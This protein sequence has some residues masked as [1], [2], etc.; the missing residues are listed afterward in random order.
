MTNSKTSLKRVANV[1]LANKVIWSLEDIIALAI[2]ADALL[3]RASERTDRRHA[4][5]VLLLQLEQIRRTVTEIRA[6]AV[7]AQHGDYVGNRLILPDAESDS[8]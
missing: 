8:S 3:A 6:L 2:R 7:G 5:P 1:R 4:D